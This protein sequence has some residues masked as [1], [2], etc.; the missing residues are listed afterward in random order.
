MILEYEP[1]VMTLDI[2]MPRMDGVAFLKRL[3]PQYY[4]PTIIV[5]SSEE[6]KKAAQDAG[7]MEF[8]PKPI[9]RT[10]SDMER[11]AN[12]ICTAIKRAY[13]KGGSLIGQ[14]NVR[15]ASG[16]TV[17]EKSDKTEKDD[18]VIRPIITSFAPTAAAPVSA[19]AP[20]QPQSSGTDNKAEQPRTAAQ[21]HEIPQN[22]CNHSTGGINGRN[23]S[24]RAGGEGFPRGHAAGNNR[25]AYACGIYK[26]VFRET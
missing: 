7:A 9:A 8:I 10:N 16:G 2:E 18:T 24:S 25:S 3:L 26:A 19:P 22:G 15:I 1:D 20:A 14:A 5:S 6:H 23:G 4:V 13:A 11:F 21:R 12:V 17:P